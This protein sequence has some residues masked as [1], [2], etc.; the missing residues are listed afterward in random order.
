[1]M[2][3]SHIDF[4][5]AST[6]FHYAGPTS[7]STHSGMRDMFSR[8]A[9]SKLANILTTT[10]LQ[11]ILDAEGSPII[12]TAVNPGPTNTDGGL[13][14]FPAWVRPLVRVSGMFVAPAKGALPIL[15]LAA[16]RE[17]REKSAAF[18]GLY[19]STK[20]GKSETPS[21]K[22]RDANLARNLWVTSME[23]VAPWVKT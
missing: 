18:K 21:V 2:I 8:Y 10:E 4:K 3:P 23:A 5:D 20:T 1:M 19:F 15:F 12:V 7:S 16:D 22:A 14:V 13:S 11:R 6:A 17:V 9:L